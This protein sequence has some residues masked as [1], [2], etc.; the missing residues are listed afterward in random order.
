MP[1]CNFHPDGV[2]V[3]SA[4]EAPFCVLRAC[5]ILN[6]A[7]PPG[8][9][10]IL[11]GNGPDCRGPPPTRMLQHGSR[12]VVPFRSLGP[13]AGQALPYVGSA[14]ERPQPGDHAPA[15]SSNHRT[16]LPTHLT[17]VKKWAFHV[18]AQ[19]TG[20]DAG[21]LASALPDHLLF[22][23]AASEPPLSYRIP[24][25]LTLADKFDIRHDGL[26]RMVRSTVRNICFI[27]GNPD[28]QARSARSPIDRRSGCLC[29]VIE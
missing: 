17:A 2:V 13:R 23:A 5:Q 22:L 1:P 15:P 7:L 10:N 19:V 21:E 3:K 24:S 28:H 26:T 12:Y 20:R 6:Q 16:A 14:S 25:F 8:V 11:S 27:V 18:R 29:G 4:A 9:L